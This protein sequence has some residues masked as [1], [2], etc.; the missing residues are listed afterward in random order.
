MVNSLKELY[1]LNDLAQMTSS[2][3]KTIANMIPP[4]PA[5]FETLPP[6]IKSKYNN[7]GEYRSKIVADFN[8]TKL[9]IK[10]K[11]S[12]RKVSLKDTFPS[13]SSADLLLWDSE[14]SSLISK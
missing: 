8:A 10:V 12:E 11:V 3:S 1:L 5:D 9:A 13:A 4:T 7:Y 14:L 6:A 2:Y